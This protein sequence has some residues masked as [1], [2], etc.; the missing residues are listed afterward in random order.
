MGKSTSKTE[1]TF[2]KPMEQQQMPSTSFEDEAPLQQPSTPSHQQQL[3]SISTSLLRDCLC[4]ATTYVPN[5]LGLIGGIFALYNMYINIF[6]SEGASASQNK[7][8]TLFRY[9]S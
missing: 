9:F 7:Y 6:N 1:S 2:K 3:P 8:L 5:V 4:L